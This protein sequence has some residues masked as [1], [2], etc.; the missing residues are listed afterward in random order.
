MAE[1]EPTGTGS[2]SDMSPADQMIK[3][4]LDNNVQRSVIDELLD[5]GF[6]SVQALSL[7]DSEDL[8][9]QRIPVGQRRLIVHIAKSL[10]PSCDNN[11][12]PTTD[13]H[14]QPV[15]SVTQVPDVYQ[16]TLLNTLL[17]QQNHISNGQSSTLTNSVQN[18]NQ[19]PNDSSPAPGLNHSSWQDPQVHLATATG[20]SASVYHD[21]CD[22]VTNTVE[23]EVVIGGQGDQQIIVKSGPKK[24]KLEALTLSQ[25]SIANLSILY[26]LV[27]EEKLAGQSLMDYLSYTTKVYQLVQRFS[28]ISVLL[29]DREYRRLQATMGFRWGT[30]VQ[31]LHTLHLQQRDRPVVQNSLGATKQ[32][33]GVQNLG[34]KRGDKRDIGICRNFN[35]VKG[36]TYPTCKFKHVCIVPGCNKPHPVMTHISEKN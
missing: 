8:K 12:L 20:K 10:S 11:S 5:R 14:V 27:G 36:C 15:E 6:D 17:T 13:V 33:L 22:F 19:A 18:V 30:D 9:S 1:S 29:Y 23:E 34:Q 32:K 31:H 25:W 24:P 2:I 3:F 35:T 26:R 7:V 28:L 4:C 21:I 16:Q